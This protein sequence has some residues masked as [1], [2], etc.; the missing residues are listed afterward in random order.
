MTAGSSSGSSSSIDPSDPLYI[1]PS[2]HP[3]FVLVSKPFDGSGFGSWKK[4]VSIALSVKNKLG[5]VTGKVVKPDSSYANF[6]NWQ[7]CD[8]MIISGS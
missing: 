8:D 3:G 2:D 1:H 6:N 4:A 5:F 7:R